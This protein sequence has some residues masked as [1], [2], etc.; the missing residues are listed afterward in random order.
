[1]R[2]ISVVDRP[3]RTGTTQ[4]VADSIAYPGVSA[5]LSAERFVFRLLMDRALAK[6]TCPDAVPLLRN[7]TDSLAEA[8][9]WTDDVRID[10]HFKARCHTRDKCIRMLHGVPSPRLWSPRPSVFPQMAAKDAIYFFEPYDTRRR[11]LYGAAIPH[12]A[13]DQALEDWL[14]DFS[15]TRFERQLVDALLAHTKSPASQIWA[16]LGDARVF[17]ETAVIAAEIDRLAWFTGQKSM[18]LANAAPVWRPA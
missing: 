2:E 17:H 4:M 13:S 18:T 15:S 14:T 3:L 5:P 6:L 12:L 16:R 11:E 7:A 9:K 8:R 10:V 1:M